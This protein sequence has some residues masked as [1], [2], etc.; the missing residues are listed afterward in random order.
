MTY[1]LGE[2]RQENERC[3]KEQKRH[4]SRIAD[5]TQRRKKA[6]VAYDQVAR[7][8]SLLEAQLAA[9]RKHRTKACKASEVS[10]IQGE[11]TAL[12]ARLEEARKA[13]RDAEEELGNCYEALEILK[14]QWPL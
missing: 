4:A 11:I 5:A 8:V 2:Y 14:K 13:S 6:R 10:R 12:L 9:L 3:K 1:M 7:E